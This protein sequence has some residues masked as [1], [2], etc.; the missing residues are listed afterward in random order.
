MDTDKPGGVSTTGVVDD[1]AVAG[2]VEEGAARE[3]AGAGG[4]VVA[5]AGVDEDVGDGGDEAFCAGGGRYDGGVDCA[6]DDGDEVAGLG[7]GRYEG[8][9][10]AA[11]VC[12]VPFCAAASSATPNKTKSA[13]RTFIADSFSALW[14]VKFS[15]AGP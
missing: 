2:A 12:A 13:P 7:G 11:P 14:P 6:G 5:E 1:A 15:L 9:D 10:C 4:A 8:F 3:G